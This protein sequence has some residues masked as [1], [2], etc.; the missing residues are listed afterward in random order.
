M[1]DKEVVIRFLEICG[2]EVAD[3]NSIIVGGTSF[4]TPDRLTDGNERFTSIGYDEIDFAFEF[5]EK[6]NMLRGAIDSHVAYS[7]DNF[8]IIEDKLKQ[9]K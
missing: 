8:K 7:S 5:D 2:M 9:T 4:D 6:G 1:T 3:H